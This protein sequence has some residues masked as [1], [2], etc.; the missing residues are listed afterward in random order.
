MFNNWIFIVILY[1]IIAVV[2]NQCYKILVKNMK[3]ASATMVIVDGLSG[4]FSLLMI[5]LFDI[6]LPENKL[7]YLFL[8]LAC[9]FYALND[10]LSTTVRKG[11]EASTFCML[12]QLST[13]FMIFAGLLFFKEKF[14][15]AKF[16]GAMLIVFGNIFV[17]YKKNSFKNNK[18]I[19]LGLLASLCSTIALFIDVSYSK[20]FNLP[21]YI[22]FTLIVPAILIL[23]FE[24]INFKDLKREFI[25]SNKK[26]L[27]T[28]C[29]SNALMNVLKLL[30]YKLGKVSIVAP[31]CSLTVILNVILGYVYLK[32]KNN[33][34]KKIIAALLI[35]L[36]IVL[37]K[38]S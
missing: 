3:K 34:F 10:R 31:L 18:Y 25:N 30:A 15:I 8:T 21:I 11:I 33:L 13:V 28:I 22:S 35:I 32:E 23:F 37:I 24:R 1:L 38:A 27:V 9:I 36:G 19:W 20:E 12:K 4:L 7:V 14:I 5:P 29:M 2:N 16:I 17:F 26:I 6:K